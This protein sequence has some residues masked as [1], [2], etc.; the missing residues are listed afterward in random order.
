M[1]LAC[2]AN[3]LVPDQCT[4]QRLNPAGQVVQRLRNHVSRPRESQ[5]II[6]HG[7][8]RKSF[9]Q[10]HPMSLTRRNLKL[11]LYLGLSLTVLFA[12]VYGGSNWFNS[13][14]G[15]YFR[16]YFP[17][18]FTIPFIA[19]MI[20]AYFSLQL[21]FLL[22]LFHCDRNALLLLAKR[23]AAAIPVAGIIFLLLPTQLGFA[24]QGT[25]S[26]Y[27]PFYDI[28]YTLDRPHNLF[29]SLH[30]TLGTLVVA[31]LLHRVRG[32][33]LW[34]YIPWLLLLY[35]SVLLVHQHHVADI[36]GG[37]VLAILMVRWLPEPEYSGYA[38]SSA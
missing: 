22:P 2:I 1:V 13:D 4:Y 28:L 27:A 38:H 7:S 18:E 19:P 11:Y 36:A 10:Q 37:I 17:W 34:L 14:R 16:L 23:M 26:F 21:L 35:L 25:A 33:L 24:R 20:L 5:V 15:Y 32:I 31:S 30:V 29:P 8:D 9:Y 6:I 12:V 3:T